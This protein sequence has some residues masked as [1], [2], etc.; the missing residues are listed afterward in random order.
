VLLASGKDAAGLSLFAPAI[1][2]ALRRLRR[3]VRGRRDT[4]LR[5][6][7]RAAVRMVVLVRRLARL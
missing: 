5:R 6:R 2:H 1:D 7:P 4:V 3:V